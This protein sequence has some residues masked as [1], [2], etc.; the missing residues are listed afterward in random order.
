MVQ[1]VHVRVLL[2][3][4]QLGYDDNYYNHTEVHI[5]NQEEY[6]HLVKLLVHVIVS[7]QVIMCMYIHVQGC[8]YMYTAK[9]NLVVDM[10]IP[11]P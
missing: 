5:C 2:H 8:S 7:T 6:S 3:H 4:I 11:I 1:E 10:Y 9:L